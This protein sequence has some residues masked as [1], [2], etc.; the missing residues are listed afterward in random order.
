MCHGTQSS[1]LHYWPETVTDDMGQ[2]GSR[3]IRAA[4]QAEVIQ[5]LGQG[6]H[7][8]EAR[9]MVCGHTHVP[10]VVSV[11]VSHG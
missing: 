2:H 6:R 4:T 5:R 10:R 9:L 11:S 7:A 3:G 1:D 8:Q